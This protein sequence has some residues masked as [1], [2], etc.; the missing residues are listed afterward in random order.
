[1]YKT[2]VNIQNTSIIL[3]PVLEDILWYDI[4]SLD[5]INLS[6]SSFVTIIESSKSPLVP[7]RHNIVFCSKY[8]L[9]WER[10]SSR[11]LSEE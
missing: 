5:T 7:I 1:M 8:F 11:D 9:L 2:K 10:I 4:M 3:H 6:I